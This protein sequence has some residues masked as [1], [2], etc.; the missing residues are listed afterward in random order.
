M[1]ASASLRALSRAVPRTS[2][3]AFRTSTTR[4]APTIRATIQQQSRRSYADAAGA[5][6]GSSAL[7]WVLGLGVV[8]AGGA[9]TFTQSDSLK[10]VAQDAK[11]AVPFT[12]KF[13]DY[14]KVYKMIAKRLE[15]HDEWDDGSF[16]PVL[17]RLAWHASGT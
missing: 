15:E 7:Y 4:F 10:G 6:S 16:G 2:T 8:G 3:S 17:L 11:A 13:E 5:K 1:A 12:P 14:E 9:Y